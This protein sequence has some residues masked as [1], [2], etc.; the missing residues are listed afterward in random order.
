MGVR[1]RKGYVGLTEECYWWDAGSRARVLE[2]YVLVGYYNVYPG[3][4]PAGGG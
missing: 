3:D 2:L 4:M 1:S